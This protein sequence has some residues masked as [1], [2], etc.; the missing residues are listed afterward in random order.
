M[1]V[2]DEYKM[3]EP[4]EKFDTEEEFI[5]REEYLKKIDELRK[6]KFKPVSDFKKHFKL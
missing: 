2:M 5:V 6:G 1:I 4:T 3:S